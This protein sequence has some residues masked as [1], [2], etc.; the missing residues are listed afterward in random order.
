MLVT[1][2][3]FSFDR[4]TD[5]YIGWPG[6]AHDARIFAYSDLFVKAEYQQDGYLFPRNVRTLSYYPI[7]I[8]Q[9]QI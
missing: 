5:V 2:Q 8:L 6:R 7:P 1:G 4:F 9:I 3:Y